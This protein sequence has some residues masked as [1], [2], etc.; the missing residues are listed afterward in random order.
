LTSL[1]NIFIL[2]LKKTRVPEYTKHLQRISCDSINLEPPSK[3][4]II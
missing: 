1:E 3:N 4:K 2:I